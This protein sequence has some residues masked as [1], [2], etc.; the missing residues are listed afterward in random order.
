MATTRMLSALLVMSL[1]SLSGCDNGGRQ[2]DDPRLYL[3][4]ISANHA[5]V[6]W[7][8][9]AG[10]VHYGEDINN[11][12]QSV[13]GT[14]TDGDNYE[15]VIT[16][17]SDDTNYFYAV[18]ALTGVPEQEF[19]TAPVAGN[20]PSD[21]NIRVWLVGDSGTADANAEAVR[22]A[23]YNYNGDSDADLF[24]LLGDNA[25][26][27]G[28]DAD[29]QK[30]FFDIYGD[31]LK[32][33]AAWSTVGNHEVGGG[34]ISILDSVGNAPYIDI[35]NFPKNGEAG[36]VPSGTEQYYSFDYG[37]VH[38]ISL[39]SQASARNS[40]KRAAMKTWLE[41]DLQASNADWHIVF[42]HHPPY[43]K[44]S[45]DSDSAG[46]LGTDRPMIDMREEFTPVFEN[47]GVDLVFTG[48]SHAYERSY[49]IAGHTGKANTFDA[50]VYAE[51]DSFGDAKDGRIDGL[52]EYDQSEGKTVYTVA[53][54]SGKISG[55]SLDHPAHFTSLNLLG[56]VVLDIGAYTL[57]AKFLDDSGAVQD[58]YSVT[59]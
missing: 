51:L 33:T 9:D 35:F 8:G 47:Y 52:G 4:Q 23:Y 43:S 2:T 54:S 38:F 48:H 37:N 53:G 49:N 7:R 18:D 25:Y 59:R 5:I 58:Y 10:S 22:D 19:T 1:T 12:D 55:G 30:A 24:I 3:Q 17:L 26:N 31:L 28:T 44:G 46:I 39:D 14:N 15:A 45:H 6:M 29:Y 50:A 57:E 11:L 41:A 42:F 32:R 40:S 20:L 27:D 36:G 34:G 16:G 56:S 13:V 21:N